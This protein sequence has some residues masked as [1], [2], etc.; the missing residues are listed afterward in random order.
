[1]DTVIQVIVSGLTLGAMYALSTIGLSLVWGSL[2][3]LNM[4]QGVMLALGGYAAYA[5]V[6][7][8]GLP[9]VLALPVAMLAGF[10]FGLLIY[11]AIVRFMLNDPAFETNVII[12]T[13]G[14]AI[15]LEN[16][17]LKAFGAYPFSQPFQLPDGLRL[18]D[19][20]VPYQNLLIIAVSLILMA[21]TAW[22]I[23]R[24][25]MGRAIRATA[26]SRDGALLMGVPVRLVFAQVLALGGVL[27]AVS[28]VMLSSITTLAPTM[29]YDPMLKA[30]IICVIAGLG[31]TMGALIAAFG[32]GVLE[33]AVQF[34]LGVRFA[35]PVLLLLV[36]VALILRPEGIF[37]RRRAV[38]Q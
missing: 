30:F 24:T 33:A 5:A 27:A 35:F 29:G 34:L 23:G 17:I 32:L 4:A 8:L 7:A 11:F 15:V 1:M 22:L 21:A 25:R 6:S 3:M 14:V 31:N 10:L 18:G 38:R 13:V 19:V 9:V 16:L 36:I 28:G 12:A 37:T 20:Y 26:Q 2:N